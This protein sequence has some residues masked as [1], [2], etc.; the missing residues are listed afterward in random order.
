MRLTISI[1]SDSRRERSPTHVSRIEIEILLFENKSKPR[2]ENN[3]NSLY[4]YRYCLG[5]ISHAYPTVATE[6]EK[7]NNTGKNNKVD[8]KPADC[9]LT[10]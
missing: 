5:P 6:R 4:R 9:V 8:T 10:S 3:L 2:L 1:A 7:L